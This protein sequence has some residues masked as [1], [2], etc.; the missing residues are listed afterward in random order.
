MSRITASSAAYLLLLS[1]LAALSGCVETGRV[2]RPAVKPAVMQAGQPDDGGIK[3]RWNEWG[4]EAFGRAASEDKLVFLDISASWCHWCKV[5]EETTYK[6]PRVVELLNTGFVPVYVDSDKRPDINDRYNQGGWPSVAILTPKGRV[7]AG[8]TTISADELL[9]LLQTVDRTFKE[10]R[11]AVL[12]RL[13]SREKAVEEAKAGP[14]K[15]GNAAQLSAQIPVNVLRAVNLF[16]D[17]EYGG[18]GGPDKFPMPEVL[19]FALYIYPKTSGSEEY[20]P[21]KALTLTLDRMADG[22]LDK[23]EGG[24]FRYSTSIDWKS[25]HYEKMLATN[26]DLLGV[27]MHAYRTLGDARYRRVGESVAG[28]MEGALKDEKTGA[29]FG[30]QAA[31]ERYYALG[32]EARVAAGAPPVDGVIYADANA[33]AALGYLEAYR[34]TGDMH[35]LAV[36][37]GLVD[38]IMTGVAGPGGKS[39]RHTP[40][41]SPGT[42]LLSDSVYSALASETL[43]QATG[44][45]VY[46][47]FA[48]DVAGSMAGKFWDGEKDGFFDSWYSS[49]PEGMLADRSK[50][51][52]ENAAAARLMTDLYHITGDM[53]YKET[54]R[55]TLMPYVAGY[56][57]H[58][59]WAAPFAQAVSSCTETSYEFIVIG[60]EADQGTMDLVKKSYMFE[61]PDRV[62]VALDPVKDME[63]VAKLGYE[64]KG[65]PVLYVCSEKAC[66]PPVAPGGSLDKTR[67][68]IEKAAGREAR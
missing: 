31:D 10:D 12:A 60:P 17:P 45:P 37:K 24:F 61:N 4:D 63:R 40:D 1:S 46:L 21:E 8:R 59:F 67:E 27:Y 18:F 23:V 6:D 2:Y 56:A 14:G 20:S 11:E 5:M 38:Y 36:A 49:K 51:Q 7:L 47:H 52:I 25:P 62:V 19:Q 44:N 42:L 50:P 29:F 3:I 55:H 26:G 28:Y 33:K 43:Y 39:V 30:S 15:G 32:Y 34:A 35:Y 48:M 58:S 64:Y 53:A 54:A 9:V 22:L 68:S 65:S 57:K 13:E 16:V 41:S 66:F